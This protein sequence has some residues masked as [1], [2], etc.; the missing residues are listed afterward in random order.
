VRTMGVMILLVF[1]FGCQKDEVNASFDGQ[2]SATAT[3]SSLKITP[4]LTRA[5]C[6]SGIVVNIIGDGFASDAD[7]KNAVKDTVAEALQVEPFGDFCFQ[8]EMQ[9]LTHTGILTRAANGKQDCWYDNRD[10]AVAAVRDLQAIAVDDRSRVIVII[11]NEPIGGGCAAGHIFFIDRSTSAHAVKHELGHA[12]GGLRD[13]YT[14]KLNCTDCVAWRNCIRDRSM[15]SWGQTAVEGCDDCQ[16]GKF[17]PQDSCAMNTN[18]PQFCSVCSTWLRDALARNS[19]G[20][21][22]TTGTTFCSIAPREAAWKSGLSFGRDVL[23]RISKDGVEVLSETTAKPRN[24]DAPYV[25]GTGL[26]GVVERRK[27][28][29]NK[30]TERVIGVAAVTD[31]TFFNRSYSGNP[32]EPEMRLRADSMVV[33]MTIHGVLDTGV[34]RDLRVKT[35]NRSSAPS[36]PFFDHLLVRQFSQTTELPTLDLGGAWN[37]FRQLQHLSTPP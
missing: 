2:S 14:T 22:P 3:D 34:I 4:I 7:L 9:R 19:F 30:V 25:T 11:S 8:L 13:E 29:S 15:A 20:E 28:S 24:L 17:R 12:I 23:L 10:K 6:T 31:D 35:L 18:R 36:R 32:H 21:V 26:I 33:A 5:G 16:N 1:G 37:Q 27:D